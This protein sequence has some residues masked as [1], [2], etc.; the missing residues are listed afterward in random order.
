MSEDPKDV[1]LE[2]VIPVPVHLGKQR[3]HAR[4]VREVFAKFSQVFRS[5]RT[6]GDVLRHVRKRSDVFGIF[7]IFSTFF[8]LVPNTGEACDEM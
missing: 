4:D 8:A 2:T 5:F 6:F 7:R 1:V 3:R